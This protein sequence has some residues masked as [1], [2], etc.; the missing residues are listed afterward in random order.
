MIVSTADGSSLAFTNAMKKVAEQ[1]GAGKYEMRTLPKNHALFSKEMG[2][3]LPNPPA[4][5]AVG[6]GVREMWIHSPTDVGAD[7]QQR[8]FTSK[9]FEL[10]GALYFYAS[11]MGSLRSKL[12]PLAVADNAAAPAARKIEVA[13]IDYAGNS[14]PEPGAWARFAKLARASAKTDLK[15]SLVKTAELDPKKFPLAHLTGT[16]RVVFNPEDVQA[17]QKYVNDGGLLFIDAAGGSHDFATSARELIKQLYPD[18]SPTPL[19]P[20]HP[21]L[22]GAFPDGAKITE[23]EF[24]KYGNITLKRRVTQPAIDHITANGRT[25]ILFSAWDIHSGFLGTST[26]GILGY[27]PSTAEALG[28]NILLYALNPA[29]KPADAAAATP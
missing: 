11:G 15:I 8:K 3:E 2:V 1:L 17:L 22:T 16:A 9:N 5:M 26:W 29:A 25:R 27:A 7:W 14:D 18:Q 12:Q 21:I 6:N 13:R 23:A 4:L 28:R 20:D 24:R 10:G 19:A